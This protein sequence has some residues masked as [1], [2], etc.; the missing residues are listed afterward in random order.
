M[1]IYIHI[2]YIYRC[3]F[4]R[5]PVHMKMGPLLD[6]PTGGCFQYEWGTDFFHVSV[7]HFGGISLWMTGI[8]LDYLDM[9]ENWLL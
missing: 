8:P 1:Y 5:S 6:G 3:F 9:S 2:I 7:L 4:I